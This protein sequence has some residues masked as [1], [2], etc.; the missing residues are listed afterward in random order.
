MISLNRPIF[1]VSQFYIRI[2]TETILAANAEAGIETSNARARGVGRCP[3]YGGKISHFSVPENSRSFFN[4]H[5][6]TMAL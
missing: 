4:V 2:G 5:L 1:K 3:T 6:P